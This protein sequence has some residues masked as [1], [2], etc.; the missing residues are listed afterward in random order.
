MALVRKLKK[1]G[2]GMMRE[3]SRG[4]RGV[5]LVEALVALALLGIIATGFLSGTAVTSTTRV[6]A[7]EHSSAKMLAESIMDSIKK[8]DFGAS[9]NITIPE[10]FPGFSA[11]TTVT[12][13]RNN[14]IQKITVDVS[15]RDNVLFTLEGYKVQR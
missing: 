9:Y 5:A 2:R 3:H 1:A 4:E 8:Q 15:R 13:L 7:D 10:E 11:N 6:T 12:S 14:A